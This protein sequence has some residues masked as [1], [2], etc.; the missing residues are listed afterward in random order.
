MRD[1][2]NTTQDDHRILQ[3]AMRPMVFSFLAGFIV[4]IGLQWGP[5]RTLAYTW[6]W[7]G[8]PYVYDYEDNYSYRD[9]EFSW[10]AWEDPYWSYIYDLEAYAYIAASGAGYTYDTAGIVYFNEG[11]DGHE[12]ELIYMDYSTNNPYTYQPEGELEGYIADSV[13]VVSG[14]C[15]GQDCGG[16]TTTAY[17][18]WLRAEFAYPDSSATCDEHGRPLSSWCY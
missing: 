6:E 3:L 15:D 5:Q 13:V 2:A 17:S 16:P 10:S 1:T 12:S 7:T 4:V 8:Q 14:F 18:A 9:M 11:G